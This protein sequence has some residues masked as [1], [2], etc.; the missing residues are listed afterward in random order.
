MAVGA[1]VGAA[2]HGQVV[3]LTEAV[4]AGVAADLVNGAAQDHLMF[5]LEGEE[6]KKMFM[7]SDVVLYH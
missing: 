3:H 7:Y 5:A 2:G 6:R 1:T 4:E